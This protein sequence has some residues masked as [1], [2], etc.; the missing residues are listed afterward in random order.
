MKGKASVNLINGNVW[1]TLLVYILPL[2]SSAMV[3]Q[4]Y[5]L[6]DLLIVG[7]FAADSNLAVNAVGNATIIVNVLLAFAFGANGG[8]S[9]VISKH[10]GEGDNTKVR[11]TVNTSLVTFSVMCAAV[12]AL[13]FA[14]GKPSMYAL[15]V[16]QS[17]FDN[18]LSYLY[19]YTASLPFVFL[20]NIGCGICSAL[21]DSKTPFVFLVVSSV[22]N[23]VLDLAFV[24][25]MHLD[26]AG[27]ALATLLSQAI[28]A[29]LTVAVL[30]KKLSAIV[31]ECK[32]ARFDGAI[33]KDLIV[34]SVP[35]ILQNS[36]ISVGNFFVSR[37]INDIGIDAT[38][39]FTAAFKLISM[40]TVGIN[41]INNGFANFCS[42]NKAA[43]RFRRIKQGHLAVFVYCLAASA[44]FM[45]AFICFP[46]PLTRLFVER[47]KLTETALGYSRSF[48]SLTASFLPFVS[49]KIVSDG[50]V[51]GTGGNI[52]FTLSTFADLILRV[53]FVYV[54]VDAGMG[55]T[56][57]GL[58]WIIGW[59]VSMFIALGFYLTV[60]CLRGVR[61]LGKKNDLN[62]N[63]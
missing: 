16:D 6:V 50:A 53:I 22:L 59:V 42:Q 55:F 31:P 13:G 61:L 27:A 58:A 60:P 3:Q 48:L 39:G 2:F 24:W 28:S 30:C 4:A 44:I 11:E 57:V 25:G 9:V 8:C 41:Q 51:R 14:L 45:T 10:F 18:C 7:N 1:K 34:T 33:C 47:E 32:P 26:V 52:G 37:R 23:V 5:S 62:Q 17:Y 36:F 35:I 15:S 46:E 12:M 20:Y 40:A 29:L 56:G 38:T 63:A 21:G 19:I 43:G 49:L 54:L